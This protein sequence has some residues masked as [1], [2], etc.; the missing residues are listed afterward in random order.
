[1]A[2]AIEADPRVATDVL[3]YRVDGAP[4]ASLIVKMTLALPA[5]GPTTLAAPE[6]V[7]A[8]GEHD[9][10]DPARS[11]ILP[12]ERTP[13]LDRCDVIFKGSAHAPR[14]TS[15]RVRFA[16]YK[17]QRA[18]FDKLADV[19]GPYDASGAPAPFERLPLV[20]ELAL[21]GPHMVENPVGARRPNI[22]DAR[23]PSV[24]FGLGPIPPRWPMRKR[25][26]AGLP[27]E[28]L[29]AEVPALTAA[30]KPAAFSAAPHDQRVPHLTSGEWLVLE[31]LTPIADLVQAQLTI[32]SGRVELVAAHGGEVRRQWL[33]LQWDGLIV[34][35]DRALAFALFRAHVP[36][37]AH[38]AAILLVS[39]ADRPLSI[40]DADALPRLAALAAEGLP[41]PEIPLDLEEIEPIAEAAPVGEETRAVSDASAIRAALPFA[42]STGEETLAVN[43]ALRRAPAIPF[44]A[45]PAASA[46]AAPFTMGPQAAP[47]PAPLV[48][49]P[50][51]DLG[52]LRRAAL[53][54]PAR[55]DQEATLHVRNLA[56]LSAE[57]EREDADAGPSSQEM[58][59]LVAEQY[60]LPHDAIDDLDP[61]GDEALTALLTSA[62]ATPEEI[63]G[64]LEA[65]RARVL[66]I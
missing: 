36:V 47:N 20:Y 15:R 51:V 1:M 41:E 46:T 55:P 63:A 23:D 59:R 57:S 43:D 30:V 49:A 10:G 48:A 27:A 37:E 42:P 19:Y 45:A 39:L 34:D 4:R 35:G 64:A 53:V 9:G 18:L 40:P 16:L 58:D 14:A 28:I 50:R 44:A 25:H 33:T 29:D 60:P 17:D 13:P 24:P 6:P 11:W 12:G 8:Q 7:R 56:A 21:G 52:E 65:R 2:L 22:V 66:E 38:P 3:H 26:L 5:Y 32:P 62:G 54:V 61:D 31:G